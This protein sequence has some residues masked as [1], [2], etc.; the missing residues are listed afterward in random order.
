MNMLKK[1]QILVLFCLVFCHLSCSQEVKEKVKYSKDM[2]IDSLLYDHFPKEICTK[3]YWLDTNTNE[4]RNNIAIFLKYENCYS[5][6]DSLAGEYE[7]KA[8]R[9]YKFKEECLLIVNS[10]ETIES[11]L[12]SD[13]VEDSLDFS[14]IDCDYSDK[15]PI[16]N[17]NIYFEG[18]SEDYDI[19]IYE[20]K[21]GLYSKY[22]KFTY[23]KLMPVHWNHGYSKGVA[24]SKTNNEIIY[25]GC[26]W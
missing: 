7:K 26:M 17:F 22:Y 20:A 5:N 21:K 24:F 1:C 19:Y 6:V 13:K 4:E 23:N 25:W 12:F 18:F 11:L 8:L 16:P 14:K 2:K 10:T 9:K 15:I 3:T